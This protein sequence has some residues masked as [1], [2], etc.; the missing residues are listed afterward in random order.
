MFW[1][2]TVY[3]VLFSDVLVKKKQQSNPGHVFPLMAGG[4][5][6][7]KG[8]L[9]CSLHVFYNQKTLSEHWLQI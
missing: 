5:R 4:L 2:G 3:K 1:L 8:A 7:W 9:R 6:G